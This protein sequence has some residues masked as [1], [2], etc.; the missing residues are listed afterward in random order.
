MNIDPILNDEDLRNALR[1]LEAIFQAA[2]P[3]PEA[4]EAALLVTLIEGYENQHYPVPASRP[5]PPR[6]PAPEL[7]LAPTH[8][9]DTRIRQRTPL[10]DAAGKVVLALAKQLSGDQTQRCHI[11]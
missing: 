9:V 6:L 10:I 11:V 8:F 4:E 5:E 7:L 3:A 2:A 1:R